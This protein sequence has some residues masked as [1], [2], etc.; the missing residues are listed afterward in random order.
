MGKSLY[1]K[2]L[3]KGGNIYNKVEKAVREC[4]LE[5]IEGVLEFDGIGITIQINPNENLPIEEEVQKQMK[6]INHTIRNYYYS[7][8]AEALMND[9]IKK[10]KNIKK[11]FANIE[12]PINH[13]TRKDL[14][15]FKFK[16][17]DVIKEAYKVGK[18]SVKQF[19]LI[20]VDRG[21][22]EYPVLIGPGITLDEIE[23][24]CCQVEQFGLDK[25]E[26]KKLGK[27][28]YINYQKVK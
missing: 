23:D 16:N 19:R 12:S 3:I 18:G 4:I 22:M 27:Q 20:N 21:Y 2:Y 1:Q 13:M 14:D 5:D 11:I 7:Q 24:Y 17:R 15:S 10:Q 28:G 6:I 26:A 9:D 25:D 8:Y